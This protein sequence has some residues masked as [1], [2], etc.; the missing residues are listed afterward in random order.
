MEKKGEAVIYKRVDRAVPSRWKSKRFWTAIGWAVLNYSCVYLQP[1]LKLNEN[2]VQLLFNK[3]SWIAGI[4]I[5]GLSAT[6]MANVKW[7]PNNTV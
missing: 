6:N 5:L 7:N 2:L 1:I 4:L 3:S